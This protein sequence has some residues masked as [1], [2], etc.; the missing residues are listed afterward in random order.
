MAFAA[1][2]LLVTVA[3]FVGVQQAQARADA[4]AVAAAHHAVVVKAHQAAAKKALEVKV[5]AQKAAAAAAAVAAAKAQDAADKAK[6]DQKAQADA[7]AFSAAEAAT[8]GDGEV[9]GFP[10][11]ATP[12]WSTIDDWYP[13]T[14]SH[15]VITFSTTSVL[16]PGTTWGGPG[17]L[18]CVVVNGSTVC[19]QTDIQ[20]PLQDGGQ[21][22]TRS[23]DMT[24]LVPA[25]G[26]ITEFFLGDP[27]SHTP[28]MTPI[29][30]RIHVQAG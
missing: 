14:V 28:N 5:A 8:G 26:T 2:V 24:G 29:Q 23:A 6:W 21:T 19:S 3:L 13:C 9:T 27:T 17:G 12:T 4:Q 16:P 30:T 1:A 7:Q 11:D 15:C 10:A 20:D 25:G 22:I 18:A